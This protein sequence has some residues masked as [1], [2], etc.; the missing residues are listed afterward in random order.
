MSLIDLATNQAIATATVV[1]GSVQMNVTFNAGGVHNLSA[2]YGGD[3]NCASGGSN[4]V[5]QS[6][7]EFRRYLVV[8]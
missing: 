3:T 1:S 6:D 2:H 5:M 7:A 8:L 4:V